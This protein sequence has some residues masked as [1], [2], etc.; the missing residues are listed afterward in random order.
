MLSRK[1]N[2][3]D[4]EDETYFLFFDGGYS[5]CWHCGANHADCGHHIFGRGGRKGPESSPFNFAPLNNHQCHLPHH[6]FHVSDE[7]KKRLFER[8]L[9]YLYG[10]GYKLTQRDEAFLEKYR[11]DIGRLKISV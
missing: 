4:F 2:Y 8:T 6:G 7:G 11:E 3:N 10:I 1:K 9:C 5:D